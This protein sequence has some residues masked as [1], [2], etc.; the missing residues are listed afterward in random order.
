MALREFRQRFKSQIADGLI[1]EEAKQKY[2][3]TDDDIAMF[4]KVQEEVIFEE[5]HGRAFL[6]GFTGNERI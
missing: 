3:M 5:K 1:L 6:I 2:Q 4:E